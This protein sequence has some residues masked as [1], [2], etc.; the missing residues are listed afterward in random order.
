M[1]THRFL[2]SPVEVGISRRKADE[3][4][5]KR[6]RAGRGRRAA[7][8]QTGKAGVGAE[9]SEYT[10]PHADDICGALIRRAGGQGG[11]GGHREKVPFFTPL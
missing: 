5:V 6:S 10:L 1:Y 2:Y 9:N 4:S 7:Y 11:G 8:V 3:L